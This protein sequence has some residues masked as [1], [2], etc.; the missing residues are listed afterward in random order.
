MLGYSF[1]CDAR[2]NKKVNCLEAK[3]ALGEGAAVI[4][5]H[6]KK[7]KSIRKTTAVINLN[8]RKHKQLQRLC[9][10]NLIWTANKDFEVLVTHHEANNSRVQQQRRAVHSIDS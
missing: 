7:E 6:K 8:Q 10:Y 3:H 4:R 9:V 2:S 1:I 5:L